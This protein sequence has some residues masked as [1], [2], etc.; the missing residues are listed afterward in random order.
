MNPQQR[1]LALAL[2]TL[3]AACRGQQAERHSC[4]ITN[5]YYSSVH[6][7]AADPAPK[8]LARFALRTPVARSKLAARYVLRTPLRGCHIHRDPALCPLALLL[9]ARTLE[10]SGVRYA[11]DLA[12]L[13][14]TIMFV[15]SSH[16]GRRVHA[17]GACCARSCLGRTMPRHV[18]TW[19]PAARRDHVAQGHLV[20]MIAEEPPHCMKRTLW[21]PCT[22]RA[23]ARSVGHFGCPTPCRPAPRAGPELRPALEQSN[24]QSLPA[25]G[26]RAHVAARAAVLWPALSDKPQ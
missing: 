4:A 11:A 7:E 2:C 16:A 5:P 6:A 26:S 17:G 22:R 21:T 10:A 19:L 8:G 15:V 12:T 13:C 3:M 18:A 14:I 25:T 1:V 20:A 24:A 9:R 23:I